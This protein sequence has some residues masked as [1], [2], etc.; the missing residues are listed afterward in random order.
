MTW[1][2]WPPKN[3]RFHQRSPASGRAALRVDGATVVGRCVDV[4]LGGFAFETDVE[5][6]IGQ[7]VEVTI[8]L[9]PG[10]LVRTMGEVVR[11]VDSTLGVRF[12]SLGQRT[13]DAIVA[14]LSD[15]FAEGEVAR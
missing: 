11:R 14:H 6:P 4:S 15:R 2:T 3:R 5:L 13:F 10:R 1:R 7:E 12:T 8:R 9:A